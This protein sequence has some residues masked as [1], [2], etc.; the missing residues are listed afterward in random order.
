MVLSKG[1]SFRAFPGT[2]EVLEE[3]KSRKISVY[4]SSQ[5]KLK[6]MERWLKE[7]NLSEYVFLLYG[8]EDGNREEHIQKIFRIEDCDKAIFFGSIVDDFSFFEG[9]E[10]ITMV[11]LNA[12][13]KKVYPPEVNVFYEPLSIEVINKFIGE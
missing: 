12:D 13:F 5:T 1:T 7:N 4:I 3:L 6:D 2:K 8:K 10:E 9:E 11:A